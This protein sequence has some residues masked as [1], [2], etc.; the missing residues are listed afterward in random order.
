[1]IVVALDTCFNACSVAIGTAGSTVPGER[2]LMRQGHAEALLPMIERV[3]ARA[4]IDW[5]DVGRIAVTHGP[6]TFTGVRTGLA[7][8]RAFALARAIPAIGF[9]S[10]RAIPAAEGSLVA[11]DAGRGRL[12][13]QAIGTGRV[14]ITPP[15]LLSIPEAA[16]CQ[17]ACGLPVIGSG[18][19]LLRAAGF[20]VPEQ[21]LAD[22]SDSEPDA[23]VLIGLAEVAPLP[24]GPPR[25][26]YLREPD[27][28]P[29]Q[30]TLLA[31]LS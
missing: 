7:A 17:S 3:M 6:G 8:A 26:L 30:A 19:P 5:G 22:P 20:A 25:P 13:V 27:A 28:K 31:R 10:L 14:E 24:D 12:F 23:A 15:Q 18:V 29:Q 4:R 9:S 1:M 21:A 2:C 11:N 16:A